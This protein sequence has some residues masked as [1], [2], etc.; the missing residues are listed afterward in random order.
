MSNNIENLTEL[1]LQKLSNNLLD[2]T[3]SEEACRIFLNAVAKQKNLSD[4]IYER[5][6]NVIINNHKKSAREN[7]IKITH[8]LIENKRNASDLC[9]KVIEIALQDQQSQKVRLFASEIL[10]DIIKNQ[11]DIILSQSLQ[12]TM[13]KALHDT[14]IKIQENI[15]EILRK[16]IIENNKSIISQEI[17]DSM[18]SYLSEIRLNINENGNYNKCMSITLVFKILLIRKY[19]LSSNLIEIFS[20]FLILNVSNN[21]DRALNY[22]AAELILLAVK[23]QFIVGDLT[24]ETL[25]NL[26]ECL[27]FESF[28]NKNLFEDCLTILFNLNEDQLKQTKLNGRLLKHYLLDANFN[29]E[30]RSNLRI[31]FGKLCKISYTYADEENSTSIINDTIDILI[32]GLDQEKLLSSSIYALANIVLTN[33][34]YLSVFPL[35]KFVLILNRDNID[36]EIRQNACLILQSAIEKQISITHNEID[37]LENAL[38]DSNSTLSLTALRVFQSLFENYYQ[39]IELIG[40]Y[41]NRIC[42]FAIELTANSN[43]IFTSNAIKLLEIF[44]QHN[45]KVEFTHD[46]IENLCIGLQINVD[47]SI[48]QSIFKLKEIISNQTNIPS[49]TIALFKLEDLTEKESTTE[50]DLIK[51]FHETTFDKRIIPFNFLKVVHRILKTNKSLNHA[52]LITVLCQCAENNL[53]FPIDLLETLFEQFQKSR[54][55]NFIQILY[56]AVVRNQ[57]LLTNEFLR[58]FLNDFLQNQISSKYT[59]EIL[60]HLIERN[61][62]EI[63]QNIINKLVQL[64]ENN[65]QTILIETLAYSLENI[66]STEIQ[67]SSK[68]ILKCIENNFQSKSSTEEMKYYCCLALNALLKHNILLSNETIN[69]LKQYAQNESYLKEISLTILDEYLRMSK[70]PESTIQMNEIEGIVSEKTLLQSRD[71]KVRLETMKKLFNHKLNLSKTLL[72]T[73]ELSF[74]FNEN[75]IEYKL[76]F[77]QICEHFVNQ[78]DSSQI[79][80]LFNRINENELTEPII[81]LL[82]KFIDKQKSF[83]DQTL[84]PLVDFV[85]QHSI[86]KFVDRV[87]NGLKI[88][89]DYQKVKI[90]L[91]QRIQFEIDSK[92]LRERTAID[93]CLEY[94]RN[95]KYQLS[96]NAIQSFESLFEN[97]IHLKNIQEQVYDLIELCIQ[98]GQTFPMN[99]LDC[100]GKLTKDKTLNQTRIVNLI[101]LLSKYTQQRITQDVFDNCQKNLSPEILLIGTQDRCQLTSKL[102]HQ[103]EAFL[104]DPNQQLNTLKVLR[105]QVKKEGKLEDSLIPILENLI[106]KNNRNLCRA[107]LNILK[108]LPTY[109]PTESF[110]NNLGTFLANHPFCSEIEL[111]LKRIINFPLR[112]KL[113]FL[114]IFFTVDFIQPD[115]DKQPIEFVCRHLLCTDLLERIYQHDKY[116]QVDHTKFFFNL[117]SFESCFTHSFERDDILCY[118]IDNSSNWKLSEITEILLLLKTDLD[119]LRIFWISSPDNLIKDLQIHWLYATINR[120]KHIRTNTNISLSHDQAE[121]IIDLMMNKLGLNVSLSECFLQHIHHINDFHELITFLNFIHEKRQYEDIDLASY[122]TQKNIAKDLSSWIID[123]QT[124]VLYKQ[125]SLICKSNNVKIVDNFKSIILEML[126]KDWSFQGF[127]NILKTK[128][129]QSCE[130]M[131]N[132]FLDSI[133]IVNNYQISSKYENDIEQIFRS[134]TSQSWL[135]KIHEFAIK[136]S[137][138]QDE[139]EKSL[140]DLLDEIKKSTKNDQRTIKLEED[141]RAIISAYNQ[142]SQFYSRGKSI[143]N[144]DENDIRAWSTHYKLNRDSTRVSELICVIKRAIVLHNPKQSFEPRTIQILSLLLMLDASKN[145]H[146]RLAQIKTGEGK[147]VII[148]MLAAIHAL[149]GHLVDIVTT[150]PLLAKRDAENKKSFYKMLSLTVGENSGTENVKSCYKCDVVYGN[151]NEYQ[152]DILKDEYSLLG[153]RCGRKYDTVIVDEVD[154]MLIDD[155]SKICRLSSH[156]PAID[157]LKIILTI[158]WQELNRTFERIVQIENKL[159]CILSPYKI[160]DN[161]KIIFLKSEGQKNESD[162]D[163]L[164]IEDPYLFIENHIKNYF[165]KTLFKSNENLLHIPQHLKSFANRQLSKWIYNA[166]QAKFAYQEN[167][168]YLISEDKYGKK[169]IVP[170]DYRNTGIVQTNT[171][172][173][174]GLHQFLQIKHKL[175]ISAENLT[176]NFLSNIEFFRRYKKNLFGLTGTLGTEDAKDLIHY[177]YNVDFVIVPSYKYTQFITYPG[178]LCQTADDWLNECIKSILTETKIHQRAVLVICESKLNA[179][180]IYEKLIEKDN[181]MKKLIKLYTRSDNEEQNAIENELDCGQIILATNLAGRGTDIG[182]T[183]KVEDNGGL[184]VLV[185]FLPLNTRVEHQAYGRTSR[186]GKRGTAQLIVQSTEKYETMDELKKMRDLK[187]KHLIHRAK[188]IDLRNIVRRDDLFKNFRKLR[189]DLRAKEDDTFKLDSLEE[190]WGLWLKETFVKEDAMDESI[191]NNLTDELVDKKFDEFRLQCLADYSSNAIFKNPFYLILKANDYIFKQKKYN[192]ALPLLQHAIQSDSI[193]SVSARYNL[194]YALIKKSADNKTQAK[195]ELEQALQILEDIFLSQQQTMFMSF[196]IETNKETK[197]KSD[198]EEQIYNRINL[199]YLC[200]AQIQEAI[201]IITDAEEKEHD[202]KLDFKV[203]DEFFSDTNKPTLDINEFKESGFVGFFH[204]T[205]KAPTPWLSITAVALLGLAQ[206]AVGAAIIV[207]SSGTAIN[208]G[209]MFL[210]EGINDMIF[211]IKCGITGEFSWKEYGIQ[212]AI[213]LTITLATCG[214]GALKETGQLMK[215]GFKGCATIIKTAAVGGKQLIGQFT[216]DSLKLVSRQIAQS[217]LKAGVKE[218]IQTVLDKT[219][220]AALSEQI[221]KTIANNIQKK[222]NEEVDKN[223]T[224]DCCLANDAAFGRQHKHVKQIEIVAARILCPESNRFISA[225][226]AIAK[227]ILNNLTNGISARTIQILTAANCLNDLMTFL[228]KFLEDFKIALGKFKDHLKIDYLLHEN[229]SKDVDKRT[230]K[231]I[232]KS[233]KG[234]QY[235]D[236]EN[237]KVLKRLE[238]STFKLKM[239]AN[240][241][242]Y[243]IKIC[244]DIYTSFNNESNRSEYVVQKSLI[245]KNLTDQLANY[246]TQRINAELINPAVQIGVNAGVE[247][248]ADKIE[249]AWIDGQKT[250]AEEITTRRAQ[251][252]VLQLRNTLKKTTD[253]QK[254]QNEFVH[255]EIENLASKIENGAPCDLTVIIALSVELGCP[256]QIYR[257]GE[258]DLT[259]GETGTGEP[260]TINFNE[261][262]PGQMGHYTDLN[263]NSNIPSTG[264]NDCFFNVLSAKTHIPEEKLREI[265]ANTVRNN[266][267]AIFQIKPSFDHLAQD[268]NKRLLYIGGD[269]A[270]HR[271][272]S[273]KSDGTYGTR[274]HERKRLEN[275]MG[276]PI[277]GSTHEF[278][279][280]I[281]YSVLSDNVDSEEKIKRTSSEG[282]GICNAGMAYAE[283]KEAHREHVTTGFS[284]EGIKFSKQLRTLLND[285]DVSGVLQ[286]QSLGYAFTSNFVENSST[287]GGQIAHNS[288]ESM[289]LKINKISYRNNDG[290]ISTLPVTNDQKVE[291]LAARYTIETGVYPSQERINQISETVNN[292]S[293]GNMQTIDKRK[294]GDGHTNK[295]FQPNS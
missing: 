102:T 133:A 8:L 263:D 216:K 76:I 129:N 86:I 54:S 56:I 173:P 161:G 184:H 264:D 215:S 196:G 218:I 62:I 229:N 156:I 269:N 134:E 107:I 266:S 219:V 187:E 106:D 182:T 200:H 146:A 213:S 277:S 149:N 140:K 109:Q 99:F 52:D 120:Y 228:D 287:I 32:E 85:R 1:D 68:Q 4:E 93:T 286:M 10:H 284:K 237:I 239:H 248:L 166:W 45:L 198:A 204:L 34:S 44:L 14:S 252:Q 126:I 11:T 208:I 42:T 214:W 158:I 63:N 268:S 155:N 276:Q 25:V 242:P 183:S 128:R 162:D 194:A 262:Q 94:V 257:N 260:V 2:E 35:Q 145:N 84:Y 81:N 70:Q 115:I 217:F 225:A 261:G 221:N 49:Y 38:N 230:A 103:L 176:T 135:N 92:N 127:I 30:R 144:Y 282:Q 47:P 164:E 18:Q 55:E 37:A 233:L 21:N 141:Y 170:I 139:K 153:T 195:F 121:K 65:N 75:S 220:L 201:A 189:F 240:H 87:L 96:M 41:V 179:T 97:S 226:S 199:M 180:K 206:A 51:Y 181:Q 256:I 211:A 273:S 59:I 246:M 137:F 130:Y 74:D 15:L 185:T 100:F 58:K 253:K 46:E 69:I 57:Q 83:S 131:M 212:K 238:T 138:D 104:Q 167:I 283:R 234:E 190:L 150:S 178:R 142:D 209:S 255:S 232:V 60:K 279:H 244:N 235:I 203:I 250:L 175:R 192:E 39:N 254:N 207:F 64:I 50:T 293:S 291:A 172:W 123:I 136:V 82:E 124:N 5:V 243:V 202:V 245:T 289:I 247:C 224:I 111:T 13:S 40:S 113:H 171:S 295:R 294:L 12:A 152:F 186:Q 285:G 9:L 20:K 73:I 231:E 23:K 43:L 258:Y 160:D 157:E 101:C 88:I 177:I 159:V 22:Q 236:Q 118:F 67:L 116:K 271:N 222:V 292:Y 90:D 270:S 78:L 278:E 16:I 148:A 61:Q 27:N 77:I 72:K 117:T 210:S 193:F 275:E 143:K 36:I 132:S 151:V 28:D 33:D 272:T 147:S 7:A 205:V 108:Y 71:S 267:E 3:S 174:D 241:E 105:N 53:I 19:K 154:S 227:G 89:L 163:F 265:A 249:R 112:I 114:Q 191:E 125:I 288:Y 66:T 197:M 259:I 274:Y 91:Q 17:I 281:P 280:A 29:D 80:F 48:R 188:D 119:S 290:S 110:F 169:S 165:E 98:N 24:K 122:F 79:Q 251:N 223:Q 31:L 168:D 6:C 95:N 26:S